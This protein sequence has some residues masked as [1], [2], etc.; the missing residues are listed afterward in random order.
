M[1]SE[2]LVS[3]LKTGI[4]PCQ[5]GDCDGLM[6]FEDEKWRDVL[7]CPKCGYSCDLD[8]YG[9]TEEERELDYPTE[10]EARELLGEEYDCEDKDECSETYEEVYNELD[11]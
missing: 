11:D 10:E 3:G 8:D 1:F 6:V 9:K 4:Y 5:N 7:I 2:K